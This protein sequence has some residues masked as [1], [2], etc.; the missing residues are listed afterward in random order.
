MTKRVDRRALQVELLNMKPL[1]TPHHGR[2]YTFFYYPRDRAK[3]PYYD[4]F[5]VIILLKMEKEYFQ[6]INLHY[7][8]TELRQDFFLRVLERAN[9]QRYDKQT[10]LRITY[11]YLG[12]YRKF[13]AF[14]SGLKNYS[15]GQV[16]GRI[17]NVPSS[18]WEIVMNLPVAWWRKQPEYKVHTDTRRQYRNA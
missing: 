12:Q 2:M 5:P 15:L 9:K 10:F 3:L 14:K 1:R 6:G 13:R 8:P 18:E 11:E 4:M 17:V 7:L 16:R